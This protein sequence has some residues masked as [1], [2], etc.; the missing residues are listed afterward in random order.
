MALA[1]RLPKLC[2]AASM[3]KAEPRMWS[4]ARSATLACS[5][6]STRPMPTPASAK[7]AASSAMLLPVA[8]RPM[9]TRRQNGMPATRTGACPRRSPKRCDGDTPPPRTPPP[10][11][12]AHRRGRGAP[13]TPHAPD[14]PAPHRPPTR[15]PRPAP[16]PTP[17][18]R[19][20]TARSPTSA[21]RTSGRRPPPPLKRRNP[22]VCGGSPSGASRARTGDLLHAMQALSQLSYSPRPVRR[23]L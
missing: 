4:G 9:Q 16:R 3:P 14:T 6:V 1:A 2:T 7:H 17:A 12:A 8:A 19:S 22:H 11:H 15:A 21:P 23:P 5:A 20:R 10:P 18:R 13:D